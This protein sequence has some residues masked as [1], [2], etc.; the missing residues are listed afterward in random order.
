MA[1]YHERAYP[2][3]D[4]EEGIRD[5]TP[6]K[7]PAASH[8]AF[9]RASDRSHHTAVFRRA[10]SVVLHA[11][12]MLPPSEL[13]AKFR[14]FDQERKEMQDALKLSYVRRG[15]ATFAAGPIAAASGIV[16]SAVTS[17]PDTGRAISAVGVAVC[18][19]GFLS[20]TLADYDLD[21]VFSRHRAIGTAFPAVM[22]LIFS[23]LIAAGSPAFITPLLPVLYFFARRRQVLDRA[24]GFPPWTM[25]IFL[26]SGSWGWALGYAGWACQRVL[27]M[28]SDTVH[29]AE[30]LATW[31]LVAYFLMATAIPVA[32]YVR[33][34]V[35][36]DA[37]HCAWRVGY[38]WGVFLGGGVAYDALGLPMFPPQYALTGAAFSFP[39]IVFL[40]Y[41]D[42]VSGFLAQRFFRGRRLQDGAFVA[43]LAQPAKPRVGDRHD[44]HDMATRTW[45]KA[46]V[47]SV[48]PELVEVRLVDGANESERLKIVPT[49]SRSL[50][51]EG[52]RQLALRSLRGVAADKIT[53]ELLQSSVTAEQDQAATYALGQDCTAGENDFFLSHS[54]HDDAKAKHDA[55]Q[56]ACLWKGGQ[57]E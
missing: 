20:M 17:S 56:K 24:P 54:W 32:L 33:W 35:R 5:A 12:A 9:R 26:A 36:M 45:H 31:G 8:S 2:C 55:L 39:S 18:M 57:R 27:A 47:T 1:R 4:V 48:K 50:T 44:W 16:I 41:R 46:F 30:R 53:L 29:D 6:T 49:P 23:M 3:I 22:V 14:R 37:T 19:A 34:S 15:V 11:H 25:V 10:A 13:E 43:E 42:T 28:N 38:T 7:R 52:L 21:E 40:L 51:A